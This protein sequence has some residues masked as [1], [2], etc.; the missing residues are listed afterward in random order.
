MYICVCVVSA[1]KRGVESAA[2][3]AAAAAEAESALAWFA[4]LHT[5]AERCLPPHN[6]QGSFRVILPQISAGTF[7]M[8]EK[9]KKKKGENL[10]RS[11]RLI[12]IPPLALFL[13]SQR[14]A[15]SYFPY[16]T[17]ITV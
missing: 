1:P 14:A 11:L 8:V 9:K 10:H 2:A 6:S 17:S 7:Y 4:S 5:N 13:Q 15:I 12:R 3:A 16:S